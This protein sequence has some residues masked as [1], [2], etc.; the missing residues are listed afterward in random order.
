MALITGTSYLFDTTV[1]IHAFRKREVARNILSQ[2]ETLDL[3]SGYSVI[4]ELELWV[5][6]KGSQMAHNHEIMLGPLQ[7]YFITIKIA[8]RAGELRQLLV[9]EVG[10]ANAPG[11]PDCVIAATAQHHGMTVCTH[12]SRDFGLFQQFGISVYEYTI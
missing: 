12:N 1:F 7:C 3:V 6:V 10:K 11:I 9:R 4:T 2:A 8:R 5:G